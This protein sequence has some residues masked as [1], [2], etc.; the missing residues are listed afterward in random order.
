MVNTPFQLTQRKQRK[1]QAVIHIGTTP[2]LAY[3][4]N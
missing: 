1:Q 3:E 4:F 2:D